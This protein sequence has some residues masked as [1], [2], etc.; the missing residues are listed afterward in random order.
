MTIQEQI[1]LAVNGDVKQAKSLCIF[2]NGTKAWDDP[3]YRRLIKRGIDNST[4]ASIFGQYVAKIYPILMAEA[5][6]EGLG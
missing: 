1:A 6:K 3:E 4:D 5:R 2:M